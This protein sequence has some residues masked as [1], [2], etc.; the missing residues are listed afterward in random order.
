MSPL[1]ETV[2]DWNHFPLISLRITHCT[3]GSNDHE[4]P[5][6]WNALWTLTSGQG[7]SADPDLHWGKSRALTSDQ[8]LESL[9]EWEEMLFGSLEGNVDSRW[10]MCVWLFCCGNKTDLFLGFW[11]LFSEFLEYNQAGFCQPITLSI[12]SI[13]WHMKELRVTSCQCI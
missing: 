5:W 6:W 11:C 7:Q 13:S 9:W 2:T 1:Q 12:N 8:L 10:T 3:W 4:R